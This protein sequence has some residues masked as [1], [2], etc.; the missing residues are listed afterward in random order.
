MKSKALIFSAATLLL[1]G[2]VTTTAPVSMGEGR[3]MIS[4]NAR[5]GFKNDGELL[6]QSIKNANA[7][8]AGK[9][10]H[11]VVLN[12]KSTGVQMWTPQNNQVVFK[13][14]SESH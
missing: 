3:Y 1:C 10:L 14:A 12:T 7:F 6:A 11:A 8:C 2:C 5:G 4:L 13:C 9:G